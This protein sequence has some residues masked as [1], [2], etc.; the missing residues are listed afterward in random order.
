MIPPD[1][2]HPCM[3]ILRDKIDLNAAICLIYIG[4]NR[5]M[6][7]P[8]RRIL[9]FVFTVLRLKK[10]LLIGITLTLTLTLTLNPN[11]NKLL[12]RLLKVSNSTWVTFRP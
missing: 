1:S 2:S 3:L 5:V 11:D 10:S 7:T 12:K 4:D 9:L 6:T 8:M